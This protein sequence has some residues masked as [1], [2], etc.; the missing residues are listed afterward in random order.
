[1]SD[2]RGR[3]LRVVVAEDH[4][5][6]RKLIQISLKQDGR[7]DVVAETGDGLEVVELVRQLQPD[8]LVIDIRLP[9]LDGIQATRRIRAGSACAVIVMSMHDDDAHIYDALA[10]GARGYVVKSGINDLP[11]AISKVSN[12]EIYLAPPISLKRIEMYRRKYDKP[13]IEALTRSRDI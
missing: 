7:F 10:A 4:R 2:E 12:G 3:K 6:V 5:A 1:M 11:E 13:P 9:G 8:V